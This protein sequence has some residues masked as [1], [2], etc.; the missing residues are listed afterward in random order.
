MGH[1]KEDPRTSQIQP[2]L[3]KVLSRSRKKL[4][5]TVLCAS[6]ACTAITVL[7]QIPGDSPAISGAL[8]LTTSGSA[9]ALSLSVITRQKVRGLFPRL[10]LALGVALALWFAAEATWVYYEVGAAIETP[11]PSMADALWLGGYVPFFYFIYG[12][13][14]NFLGLSRS[15]IF[16]VLPIGALGFVLL[17]N[18]LLSIY[19]DADLTN[20]TGVVSFIVASAYPVADMFIIIPAI[21][22][23]AQLRKGL[24]TF[25][26]W[27][28]IVVATI[29]FILGDIGFAYSTL[30]EGMGELIWVWNPLYNIAYIAIASSLFWHKSF[31]TVDERK[32]LRIWQEKN[33]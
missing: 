21:A 19:L 3:R 33:K 5:I 12:I 2:E 4:L 6:L 27:F 25:T 32:E 13:L 14:K 8:A 22:A 23:F 24:L 9:F 30:I 31:F 11:F 1:L 20:E 17:G 10:Y 26:P 29:A 15:L 28:L 7:A 16:P 18:M